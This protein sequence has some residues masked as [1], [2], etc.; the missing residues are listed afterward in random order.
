M[1]V[2]LTIAAAAPTRESETAHTRAPPLPGRLHV[3]AFMARGHYRVGHHERVMRAL[4]VSVVLATS[5]AAGAVKPPAS[6]LPVVEVAFDRPGA[7]PRPLKE[8][9]LALNGAANLLSMRV[10][11]ITYPG[12]ACGFTFRGAR[13]PS[14]AT[15]TMTG[16]TANGAFAS[17]PLNVTWTATGNEQTDAGSGDDKTGKWVFVAAANTNRNGPGWVVSV[18]GISKDK[19]ATPAAVTCQ[20]FS[21][22][23]LTRVNGPVGYWA[24][25]ATR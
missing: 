3:V 4:A 20:L 5:A 13:P 14:P 7:T 25:F 6:A 18:T 23:T 17:G 11:K 9:T 12:V 21:A 24:G 8:T 10:T 19:S 1:S 16:R 15:V 2:R 22:A